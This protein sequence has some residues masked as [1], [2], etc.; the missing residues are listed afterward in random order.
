MSPIGF[1]DAYFGAQGAVTAQ[2]P[3]VLTTIT[4]N[5]STVQ[6]SL[7]GED[8]DL[9]EAGR[10]ELLHGAVIDGG[11]GYNT[12][13][14][15]A[16][17]YFAQPKSLQNIQQINIENLP[18]IYTEDDFGSGGGNDPTS[19]SYPNFGD[20]AE[21]TTSAT[22]VLN[23]IVDLT[24]AEDIERLTITEGDFY[25][26]G[27][28]GG[29]APGTLT[30][31]GVRNGAELTLDGYFGQNLRVNY[32]GQSNSD[33]MDVV[34]NGVTTAPNAN[35]Y[36][37]HNSSTLNI[38]STGGG[39][40][41]SNGNFSFDPATAST[42]GDGGNVRVLN[43]SGDGYLHIEGS[44]GGTLAASAP[45]VIDASD[46]TAGVRLIAAGSEDITFT[47]TATDDIFRAVTADQTGT[48]PP[49]NDQVITIVSSEGNDRYDLASYTVDA[50]A[51]D[52]DNNFEVIA[53]DATLSAGEGN[54]HFEVLAVT[55]SIT[56][57][58]GDNRVDLALGD[59]PNSIWQGGVTGGGGNSIVSGG[60]SG[61]TATS[62]DD[63]PSEFSVTLGDGANEFNFGTGGLVGVGFGVAIDNEVAADQ[64]DSSVTFVGGDG[65]NKIVGTAQ[66][67]DITTGGGNDA[68]DVAGEVI[69]ISTNGGD[70]KITIT[71][72]DD[73]FANGNTSDDSFTSGGGAADQPNSDG[74]DPSTDEGNLNFFESGALLNIDTGSGSA[75][76]Y[77]GRGG[78]DGNEDILDGPIGTIIAEDGSVITGSDITLHVD[79]FA[80]LV[81]AD[82]S[83]ITEVII[84]D[85]FLPADGSPESNDSN[86]GM[87]RALLTLT[88]DQFLAIGAENFSVEGST[89]NTQGFVKIVIDQDMSLDDLGVANLSNN[90][91]LYIEIKDGAEFTLTAQQLHENIARDGIVLDQDGNTDFGSGSVVVTGGGINFDPYNESDFAQTNLNG[92]I[93]FGGS[94]SNDFLVGNQLFN[95]TVNSVLGGYNRPV[96]VLPVQVFTIDSDVTP[97]VDEDLLNGAESISTFHNN[98]EIVGDSDISFDVPI[99]AGL[100]QG[101][102][103]NLFTIDFSELQGTATGLTI[104]NFETVEEVLGNGGAEVFIHIAGDS[105][106]DDD[107]DIGFD[108]DDSIASD[109]ADDRTF[110][111]SGVSRYVVT[112][113]DGGPGSEH[114]PQGDT[115]TIRLNDVTRDVEIFA[116]EGNW[117]DE[118]IILSAPHG[119]DFE[120]IG[121]GTLKAEGPTLTSNVGD[122]TVE[123]KHPGAV[124]DVAI[125]H[126][127]AGDTRPIQT[128][129]IT[130][131]N[132]T[133]ININATGDDVRVESVSD[134]GGET[135]DVLNFTATGDLTVQEAMDGSPSTGASTFDAS[136]VAGTFTGTIDG[137]LMMSPTAPA[138]GNSFSFLGGASEDDLTLINVDDDRAGVNI[139]GGAGGAALTIGSNI[140]GGG[141]ITGSM[142]DLDESTLANITTIW[143]NSLSTLRIQLD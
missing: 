35:L 46:N 59:S 112:S 56:A 71:G 72:F 111:T 95:V 78:S 122:L 80:N 140:D 136:A 107:V 20:I 44:L 132:A 91:D 29:F 142:V 127:D 103:A 4:N 6:G 11:E 67:V 26:L 30:V 82:L 115:A 113:I 49:S 100:F 128:G 62:W 61:G 45:V 18:N 77:L 1:V 119:L 117:N 143:V 120:L 106:D 141:A 65:G 3:V 54:N 24:R 86:D 104:G 85:D 66:T 87:D 126:R 58:D 74:A 39:S 69:T 13:E 5:G 135:L 121:G 99:N 139:D 32:S 64:Y 16:K 36:F 14:I 130:I 114:A 63:L 34:L 23:S 108:D 51:G 10:L 98:I 93:Y 21:S 57:G 33:G 53:A 109:D 131:N 97:I 19:N 31:T 124:T 88:A 90:I 123:F 52:G 8:N 47:G 101:N 83:G 125:F 137:G 43:I 15:D 89:F 17:G 81:A 41:I 96:D 70:D 92:R 68:I 94:L 79:T 84:D 37:A 42:P 105:Q 55:G 2:M 129:D 38:E 40:T 75:D 73:D 27:A 25:N 7:T 28:S 60:G 138:M 76:I 118:L 134:A 22:M 133:T 48:L 116:L 9:I 110:A 12:L 102:S 50:A